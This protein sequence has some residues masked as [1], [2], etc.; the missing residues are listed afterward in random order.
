MTNNI[1]SKKTLIKIAQESYP[2]WH[3]ADKQRWTNCTWE[4]LNY[5]KNWENIRLFV[6]KSFLRINSEKFEEEYKLIKSKF[7]N[8][9]PNQW[10]VWVWND[11]FAFC[12]P[13]EIKVDI[14]WNRNKNYII[15]LLKQNKKLLKQLIFFIKCYEEFVNEWKVVDLQWDENLVISDDNKLYYT[16]SFLVLSEHTKKKSLENLELLKTLINEVEQIS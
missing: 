11:V 9:V 12:S 2:T 15:N 6:K 5:I 8:I 16:D 7:K 13:I 14:L 4:M 3:R 10:F 1:P